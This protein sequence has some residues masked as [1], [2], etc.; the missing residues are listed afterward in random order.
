MSKI[1]RGTVLAAAVGS[2]TVYAVGEAKVLWNENQITE[3]LRYSFDESDRRF[4]NLFT[5]VSWSESRCVL[6]IF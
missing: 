4:G 5:Q 1:L 3:K 2:A 6:N